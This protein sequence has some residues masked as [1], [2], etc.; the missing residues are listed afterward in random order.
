MSTRRTLLGLGA[1]ALA[2]AACSGAG[3]GAAPEISI[4]NA[5]VRPPA[6]GRDIG[7]AYLVI[8]NTGGQDTLL[9]A[10]SPLADHMQM[11]ISKMDGDMMT[12][13]EE[14]SLV[15]PAH[16]TI[17]Y[18]PGG[19]HLMMFGVKSGLKAGD[20]VPLTL[21]FERFGDISTIATVGGAAPS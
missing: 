13:R 7:A 1:A 15:I 6:G 17:T 2:L 10:S 21:H 16:F 9:G 8:H 20:K 19:R 3:T 18:A 14:K 11:H 5:W 4:E 12:M